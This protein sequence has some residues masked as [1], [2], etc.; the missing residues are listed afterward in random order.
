MTK[1]ISVFN[2]YLPLIAAV[3][4]IAPCAI[5]QSKAGKPTKKVCPL[6]EDYG[7]TTASK[8]SPVTPEPHRLVLHNGFLLCVPESAHAAHLRHGDIDKG[9]CTKPGRQ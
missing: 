4:L 7:M 9:P 1:L 3:S 2:R 6:A 5:A 8:K